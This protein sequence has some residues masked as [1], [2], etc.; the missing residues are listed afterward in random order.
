MD[1][2]TTV[3]YRPARGPP[4]GVKDSRPTIQMQTSTAPRPEMPASRPMTPSRIIAPKAPAEFTSGLQR[5]IA[6][7]NTFR[8]RTERVEHGVG[9]A[10]R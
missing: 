1:V 10:S 6:I 7:L 5:N 2:E 9:T 8:P 3:E 4:G